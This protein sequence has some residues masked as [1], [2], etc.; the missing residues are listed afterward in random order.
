MSGSTCASS[1]ASRALSTASLMVVMTPLVG[2]S[3]PNRCLFFSKNS[4]TLMLRC[5]FA[6][7]SASTMRLHLGDRRGRVKRCLLARMEIFEGNQAGFRFPLADNG[8]KVRRLG[9]VGELCPK[10]AAHQVHL[11]PD[12]AVPEHPGDRER[13]AAPLISTDN[14][15]D[16]I[17]CRCNL[18]QR[19][20]HP[21]KPYRKTGRGDIVATEKMREPVR[22][23]AHDLV[24]RAE[25][26]GKALEDH[27]GVVIQAPGDP[28]VER[29]R[30]PGVVEDPGH[31]LHTLF[32]RNCTGDLEGLWERAAGHER[33]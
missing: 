20:H 8:C 3:N 2:E 11:R 22:P 28:E 24:L 10:A 5:C 27:A 19:Y 1:H 12:P 33:G 23:A 6:S 32:L 7:S 31:L 25:V 15:N 4:A 13:K 9:R 14:A 21:V 30:D 26:V 17:F 29:V 18:T 16:G